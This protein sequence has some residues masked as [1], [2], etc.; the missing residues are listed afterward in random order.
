MAHTILFPKILIVDDEPSIL[1]V[2]ETALEK[3]GRES[4]VQLLKATNG[5]NALDIIKT[6]RP[7]LVFL[8]VMMPMM[9]GLDV[10]NIVKNEMKLTEVYIVMLTAKGQDFDRNSGL[11][12]GADCYMT[13]PFRPR[14]ILSRAME[15]LGLSEPDIQLQDV[16]GPIAPG[17]D[18][19]HSRFQS[20]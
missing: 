19:S 9:S 1:M 10:C 7:N 11:T 12:V 2:M 17:Q 6:V 13:K 3:L 5:I 14:E 18:R 20:N 8:D 15:V 16:G 4:Q